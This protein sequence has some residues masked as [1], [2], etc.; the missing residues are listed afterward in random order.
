LELWEIAELAPSFLSLVV[1]SGLLHLANPKMS[2]RGRASPFY[3]KPRVPVTVK[4]FPPVTM[5]SKVDTFR[6]KAALT[7]R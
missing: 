6:F 5:K 7:S 4:V 2:T 3:A 1:V